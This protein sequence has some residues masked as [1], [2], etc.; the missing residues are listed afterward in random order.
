V[1]LIAQ[2]AM[3]APASFSS[4]EEIERNANI[5]VDQI[6]ASV[7]ASRVSGGLAQVNA[8]SRRTGSVKIRWAS[9][10]S[11]RLYESRDDR[12]HASPVAI[13]TAA[14]INA[15]PPEMAGPLTLGGGSQ[16]PG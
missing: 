14:S 1:A 13:G 12:A 7:E 2:E 9:Q 6:V 3:R 15:N 4:C 5:A 11:P 10:P 8:E 16:K